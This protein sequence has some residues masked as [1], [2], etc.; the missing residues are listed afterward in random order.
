M[1]TYRICYAEP[2]DPQPLV[3]LRPLTCVQCGAA[4]GSVRAVHAHGCMT[5]T[6]VCS[7]FPEARLAVERHECH[8][9]VG[10]G[11]GP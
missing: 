5:A 10:H 9:P 2:A 1:P 8:Y 6:A 3:P 4:L 7:V 11:G